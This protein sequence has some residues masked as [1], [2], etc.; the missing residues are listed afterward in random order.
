MGELIKS[1]DKNL[2]YLNHK[3]LEKTIYMK[4]TSNREA[5]I[6]FSF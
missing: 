6:Y 1:L 5:F 4:V 2:I 3:T